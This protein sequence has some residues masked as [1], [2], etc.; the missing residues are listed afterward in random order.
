MPYLP[1]G[2]P[3]QLAGC[4]GLALFNTAPWLWL[5]HAL[6]GGEALLTCLSGLLLA[7]V[8][9]LSTMSWSPTFMAA[10]AC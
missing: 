8:A 2:W 9:H 7:I 3:A 4:V 1:P 10:A 6:T 5:A